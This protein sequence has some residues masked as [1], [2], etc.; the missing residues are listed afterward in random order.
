MRQIAAVYRR[1]VEA[2]AGL[3]RSV[4]PA[5][6]IIATAA[7]LLG[8]FVAILAPLIRLIEGLSK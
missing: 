8:A 1:Q 7:V 3:L 4:L 6:M 5:F 2:R